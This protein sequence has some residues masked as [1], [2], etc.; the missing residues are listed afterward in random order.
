[1]SGNVNAVVLGKHRVHHQLD[2]RDV[3][4]TAADG[5]VKMTKDAFDDAEKFGAARRTKA[6]DRDAEVAVTGQSPAV[7]PA[8]MRAADAT[9]DTASKGRRS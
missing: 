7:E 4:N 3:V 6:E 2:G 5:V 9:D 8:E 1:M